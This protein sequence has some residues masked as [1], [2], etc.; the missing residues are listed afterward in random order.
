PV[1]R[2]AGASRGCLPARSRRPRR[3]VPAARPLPDVGLLPGECGKAPP[4]LG[5]GL[6]ALLSLLTVKQGPCH[7]PQL[8]DLVFPGNE[9]RKIPDTGGG[10]GGADCRVN[11]G[12]RA[13]KI[14]LADGA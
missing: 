13:S 6:L 11:P 9:L 10:R 5:Y 2:P 1:V 3:R 8:L 4:S 14:Y 12:R 7:F